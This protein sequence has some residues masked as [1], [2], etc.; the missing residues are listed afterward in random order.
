[1]DLQ[2]SALSKSEPGMAIAK[3]SGANLAQPQPS[4]TTRSQPMESMLGPEAR[5]QRI[6][7]LSEAERPF[8]V[9]EGAR[10]W[11][12]QA[13]MPL[14]GLRASSSISSLS[15]IPEGYNPSQAGVAGNPQFDQAAEDQTRQFLT[16][17]TGGVDAARKPFAAG[18][19]VKSWLEEA[20]TP[21][22]DSSVYAKSSL[23]DPPV[24]VAP[25]QT[26]SR[27][28]NKF[29]ATAEQQTKQFLADLIDDADTSR[30]PFAVGND[31][32][33]W[34]EAAST[35]MV[36]SFLCIFCQSRMEKLTERLHQSLICYLPMKELAPHH[37][38]GSMLYASV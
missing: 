8:A 19:A 38:N 25:G 9:G 14:E 31:S 5:V 30:K 29:D 26:D 6:V 17:I 13:S 27:E 10:S 33:G 7:E 11:L 21:M 34:L 36:C 12:E 4:A 3:E 16:G 22:G 37:E 28:E 1:M 2:G 18:G 23:F 35:P 20:S 15:E 32:P 24:E